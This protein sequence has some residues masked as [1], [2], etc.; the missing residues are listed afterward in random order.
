MA[1]P[2]ARRRAGLAI[3]RLPKDKNSSGLAATATVTGLENWRAVRSRSRVLS[4]NASAHPPESSGPRACVASPRTSRSVSPSPPL[5]NGTEGHRQPL[6]CSQTVIRNSPQAD[7]RL[8]AGGTLEGPYRQRHVRE[9]LEV[10]T[11]RALRNPVLCG[12]GR[13]AE[14][15]S[16]H[17]IACSEA[18]CGVPIRSR[19]S[20]R[21]R[22]A[23]VTSAPWGSYCSWSGRC[24]RPAAVAEPVDHV[25]GV[26]PHGEK[27][28]RQDR[29]LEFEGDEVEAGLRRDDSAVVLDLAGVVEHRQVKP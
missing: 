6:T 1:P 23:L 17:K 18:P 11:L 27:G 13:S 24:R 9:V 16:P 5:P 19:V 12:L 28:V 3:S 4:V 29:V 21:V 2:T 10:R 15:K 20:G 7:T 14:A 22:S 26:P 25:G 8:P